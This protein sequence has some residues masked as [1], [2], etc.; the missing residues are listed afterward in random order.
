MKLYTHSWCYIC[1]YTYTYSYIQN[2]FKTKIG[3][4]PPIS[5]KMNSNFPK[6][7]EKRKPI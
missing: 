5:R 3:Y 2:I 6:K 7:K 1:I 4:P